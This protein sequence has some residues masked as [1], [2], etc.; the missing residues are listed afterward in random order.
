VIRP[1]GATDTYR[2]GKSLRKKGFDPAD[3]ENALPDV[4]RR[5]NDLLAGWVAVGAPIELEVSGPALT[6]LRTWVCRLPEGTQRI[7]C[8]GTHLSSLRELTGI[9]VELTFDAAA[10]EM[11]MTTSATPVQRG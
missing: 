4:A 3:L 10:G 8:G 11:V 1:Y 2:V 9:A 6:D 7:P 5:A